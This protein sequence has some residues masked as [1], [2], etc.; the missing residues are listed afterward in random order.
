MLL[1][2]DNDIQQTNGI[3]RHHHQWATEMLLNMQRVTHLTALH[4]D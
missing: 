1:V 4:I 2:P 3:E